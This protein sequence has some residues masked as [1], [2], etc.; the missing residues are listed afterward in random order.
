LGVLDPS[1]GAGVLALHADR[2]G[3]LLEIAGLVDDQR[4]LLVAQVLHDMAA[5]VVADGIVVPD[6]AGQQVLH[7]IGVESP[8][9]LDPTRPVNLARFVFLDRRSRELYRD[10][11]GIAHATVG[12]LR[13]EAGRTPPGQAPAPT[14]NHDT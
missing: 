7:P 10:W 11:D 13:A 12:S 8:A 5:D 3:A 4:R 6:R 14:P 2:G 9:F 1:S